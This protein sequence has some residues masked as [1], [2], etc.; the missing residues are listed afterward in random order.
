[1]MTSHYRTQLGIPEMGIVAEQL[2][3]T[4]GIG[5]D[6]IQTAI[7][8]THFSPMVLLTLEEFRFCPR[9]RPRTS[10][11]TRQHRGR[12][13]LPINTNG[14]QLGEAYIHGMNGIAEAVRQVRGTSVNQ[15]ANVENVLATAGTGVPTSASSSTST[16]SPQPAGPSLAAERRSQPSGLTG[17]RRGSRGRR[18]GRARPLGGAPAAGHVEV[19]AAQRLGVPGEPDRQVDVGR[20]GVEQHRAAVRS[21]SST[22]RRR[23]VLSTAGARRPPTSNDEAVGVVAGVDG[24]VEHA[25]EVLDVA[26]ADGTE[27]GE[28][29]TRRC[30]GISGSNVHRTRPGRRHGPSPAGAASAQ[31]RRRGPW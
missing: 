11:A 8:T 26:D 5:P 2:Y 27:A 19:G 10:R 7:P 21:V 16:A 15:V 1:M 31:R 4:A 29:G 13:R 9:A 17:R 12:R 18:R 6:D 28:G 24:V 23:L 3:A 25:V 22:G 30:G 14:G 20:V